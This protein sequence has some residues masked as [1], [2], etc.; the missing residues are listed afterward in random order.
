MLPA[1]YINANINI[2]TNDYECTCEE[3]TRALPRV[4]PVSI[5]VIYKGEGKAAYLLEKKQQA[6]TQSHNI[7]LSHHLQHSR[8]SLFSACIVQ[9]AGQYAYCY[10]QPVTH[11]LKPFHQFNHIPLHH[12]SL[13]HHI[14]TPQQKMLLILNFLLCT[15]LIYSLLTLQPTIFQS[16]L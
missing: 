11:F 4:T 8:S 6:I 13:L 9:C 16:P 1:S 5:N 3:L 10:L 15:L 2:K 12:L 14:P 7:R